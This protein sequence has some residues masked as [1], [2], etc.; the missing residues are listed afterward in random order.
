MSEVETELWLELIGF[1]ITT[2]ATA[3]AAYEYMITFD[4]EVEYI[5][6]KKLTLSSALLLSVRWVMVLV[7]VSIEIPYTT[8]ELRST[9]LAHGNSHS[10]GLRSNG[11]NLCV[12]GK[13]Y[14]QRSL[15]WIQVV[16]KMGL[17]HRRTHS[18]PGIN[19]SCCQSV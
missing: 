11:C 18:G 1:W 2:G 5:W 6:S 7:A 3:L 17:A 4:K 14:D 10:H 13:R 16:A 8:P 12:E 9:H 15:E 19:A